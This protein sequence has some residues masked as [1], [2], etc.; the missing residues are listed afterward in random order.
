MDSVR[1]WEE[2]TGA[3][4]DELAVVGGS[5]MMM[6]EMAIKTVV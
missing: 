1:L 2:T 6:G 5:S 4:E 3:A